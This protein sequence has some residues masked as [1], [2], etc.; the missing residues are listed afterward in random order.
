MKLKI[1]YE[2]KAQA[3]KEKISWESD[4]YGDSQRRRKNIKCAKNWD[5]LENEKLESFV[6][7]F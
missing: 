5:N 1:K 3:G 7:K 6:N 4:I 2:G